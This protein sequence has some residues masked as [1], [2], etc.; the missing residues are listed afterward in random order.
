[1]KIKLLILNL[2]LITVSACG[3]NR[4]NKQFSQSEINLKENTEI[5]KIAKKLENGMIS[6]MEYGETEYT[7]NDVKKCMTLIDNYLV[8]IS[9]SDSKKT[10]LQSVKKVILELNKLN[11]SCGSQLIETDQREKIADIIILSGYL[12]GYNKRNEDI[13]EE[14]REW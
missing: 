10:G 5:K 13:T 6:F 4:N 14:W 9:K 8:E 2:I 1:M 3:Q 11:E 12:K 7:K